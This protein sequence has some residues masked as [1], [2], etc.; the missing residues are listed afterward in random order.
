MNRSSVLLCVIALLAPV[1]IQANPASGDAGARILA[2]E[3]AELAAWEA[4]DIEGIMN[5]YAPDAVVMPGGSVIPDAQALRTF[6]LGFLADPGFSLTFRSD[7][8]LM[9]ASEELGVTVGTYAVTFTDP[10]SREVAR[11][12]GRHLMTWKRQ[13]DGHWRIVRQMTA[14]D[15]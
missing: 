11:R 3:A 1:A 10:A 2:A 8:P 5:A 6:F 7:P 4:R 15:R 13:E 14:H 12:T 9:A